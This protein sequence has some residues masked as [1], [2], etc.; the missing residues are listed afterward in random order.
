MELP[1]P[2][3]VF[4]NALTPINNLTHN[5]RSLTHSIGN[6]THNNS[7]AIDS[8]ETR[9]DKGRF[10]SSL[11]DKPFVDSLDVLSES[12]RQELNALA[13]PAREQRRLDT[14]TMKS[15]ISGLCQEHYISVSILEMILDRKP[16]SLRQNYLKPMISEGLLKMAFPHKPNSPKQGY[17]TAD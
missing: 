6:L 15:L 14:V 9:D 7:N 10:I 13:A 3:E 11:I 2:E 17:T 4:S 12:F 16:Q 8:N 1:S 5:A